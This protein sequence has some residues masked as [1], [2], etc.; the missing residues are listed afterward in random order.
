MSSTHNT[1]LQRHE[2]GPQH[3]QPPQ[4]AQRGHSLL[5]RLSRLV[6]RR[7]VSARA[8]DNGGS[9]EINWC[10]HV[11]FLGWLCKWLIRGIRSG[12]IPIDWLV[13]RADAS[14]WR[15]ATLFARYAPLVHRQAARPP[16]RLP[17]QP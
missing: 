6:R 1:Q 2:W 5:W 7:D 9:G 3:Q 11:M 17:P 16:P 12:H 10:L 14:R 8:I 4:P 15:L 13:R